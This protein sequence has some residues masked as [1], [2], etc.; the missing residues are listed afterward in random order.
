MARALPSR[1]PALP[2]AD[3]SSAFR[4]LTDAR[5]PRT[6]AR[7]TRPAPQLANAPVP[8]TSFFCTKSAFA[9]LRDADEDDA[10]ATL[11]PAPTPSRVPSSPD[12]SLT[13]PQNPVAPL[14]DADAVRSAAETR[15]TPP[16]RPR[17]PRPAKAPSTAPPASPRRA[18]PRRPPRARR[19]RPPPPPRW[20]SSERTR[21]SPP[22]SPR[23]H[24]ETRPTRPAPS[25]A[26]RAPARARA[27]RPR[28]RIFHPSEGAS[29]DRLARDDD[30]SPRGSAPR[31]TTAPAR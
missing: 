19:P 17:A 12:R 11:A 30:I 13:L 23:V 20:V 16:P 7:E 3:P 25:R 27:P 9:T 29:S 8:S 31:R 24:P 15:A 22:R 26:P 1:S 14:S 28:P 4:P 10:S 6:R 5:P 18:S 21:D 2:P